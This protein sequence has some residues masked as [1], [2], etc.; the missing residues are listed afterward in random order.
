MYGKFA[1]VQLTQSSGLPGSD[2][3]SIVIRGVGSFSGTDPLV[4]I[5]NIQYVGLDAF[6]SL[7]PS[8]IESVSVLKDASA[9]SIYGARGANGVIIVTTKKGKSG[10]GTIIFNSYTGL[11]RATVLPEFLDAYNYA[12]LKNEYYLNSKGPGT[13]RFTPAQ[14]QMI[15]DQS[16]PDQFANTNW[17]K[18]IIKDAP[19]QNH[20]LS[21]SGGNDRTT[22]RVS[23]GYLSQDAIV[24]GKFKSERFTVSTNLDSKVNSWLSINNVLNA[25]WNKFKGPTDGPGAISAGDNG[26]IFQFQRSQPTVPVYYSNG[27][28]GI[29]DGT[30]YTFGNGAI[31]NAIRN[32]NSGDYKSNSIN[33]SDRLGVKVN[34]TKNLILETSGSIN[35][36][37][38]FV[39]NYKAI[40][41]NYDYNA[42]SSSFPQPSAYN[43]LT[44]A[45]TLSYQLLNENILRY[46]KKIKK[47]DIGVLVGH[48]MSYYR[49]DFFSAS[50]SNFINDAI[51]VLDGAIG[52]PNNAG[53]AYET[54]SQSIFSRVNYGYKGRYLLELNFRRDGSSKFGSSNVYE[55]YPSAS[56]GW[57]VSQEEFFRKKFYWISDMKLRASWG[58][59]GNDAIAPY[60]YQTVYSPAALYN[61]GGSV[62]TGAA[63]TQ[64]ANPRVKWESV[65]QTNF[66]LDISFLKNRLSVTADYFT[67]NSSNVLYKNIPVPT[68]IGIT[69]QTAQNAADLVNSGLELAVNFQGRL[70]KI[71]YSVGV[72]GSFFNANEVTGLGEKGL[73]TITGQNIIRKGVPYNAYYGLKYVGIFQTAGDVAKAPVQYASTLTAPGDM[74]YADISGPNG[75]PDGKIDDN[76]LTVIGN[77]YPKYTYNFNGNLSYKGIDFNIVFHG[78]AG[79][80]RLLRNNGQA[81]MGDDVTNVLAFWVNRWTPTNPSLIYPRMGGVNN[82]KVSSY[83]V[84]DA[85]YLRLKNIE[86]GYTIP[87]SLT[88][89]FLITKFRI[90]VSAQ[91]LLTFTKMK[92]YDPERATTS[93]TYTSVT[94]GTSITTPSDQL[95]PLYK[96]YTIGLNLKF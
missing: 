79:V 53:R 22:Y 24:Q 89:R 58:I 82:S 50:T 23:L 84:E 81:P 19:I 74:Q 46:N 36:T 29:I 3:S 42:S 55:N 33:V 10:T 90:Y 6:N 64:L 49:N 57:R 44:D 61:I 52:L 62:L 26:I 67:K 13:Y 85:S 14:L 37:N 7:S 35:L 87:V 34:L 51:Q 96:V 43:T 93:L 18:E 73:E 72:S 91:N 66:G 63:I 48:S 75:V 76:D 21:F 4:V 59:A 41:V 69:S 31:A 54:T 70:K 45:N 9:I 28:F 25:N 88:K 77:P 92:N 80:D 68:S 56:V 30:Y 27:Y 20:Y 78:L 94:S 5:D 47:H 40:V 12:L 32:G 65:Q 1:G 16:N 15:Q 11:Q 2:N 95:A 83:Y 38:S 17:V 86:I 60:A 71:N 8:D 39:S